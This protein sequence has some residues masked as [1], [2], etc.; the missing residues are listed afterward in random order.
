MSTNYQQKAK[1]TVFKEDE[2]LVEINKAIK[3]CDGYQQGM[4][5]AKSASGG[6]ELQLNGEVINQSDYGF[7]LKRAEDLVLKIKS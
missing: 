1:G 7:I 2:Y 6:T 5:V 3:D 4:S